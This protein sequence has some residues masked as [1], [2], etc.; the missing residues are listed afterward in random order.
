MT[1][2]RTTEILIEMAAIQARLEKQCRC[3]E[4]FDQSLE[5]L[6]QSTLT[7]TPTPVEDCR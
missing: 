1:E 3:L 7:R 2:Q 5:A 6:Y 4:A